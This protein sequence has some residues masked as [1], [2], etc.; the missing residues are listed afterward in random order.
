MN[1]ILLQLGLTKNEAKIYVTLLRLGPAPAGKITEESGIH[2]RNVYDSLERLMAKGLAGHSTRG[3]IRYFEAANP[4]KLLELI[5]AEKDSLRS[6]EKKVHSVLTELLALRKPIQKEN[7]IIYKGVEG[8]KTILDDVLSTGKENLVLG[9]H[10]PP[11]QIRPYLER[12]HKKRVR[13]GLADKLLFNKNDV[14]RARRLSKMPCTE[15]KFL[16]KKSE[17]QS[18]I[19]IYGNKVAIIM[20][21]DPVGILIENRNVAQAFREYFRLLWGIS[22]SK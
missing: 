9:A 20:W 18:S 19:N 8:V 10:R 2:R 21:S 16:P 6:K 11:A 15:I 17:S 12:F 4:Y 5:S 14:Q 13:I 1:D 3:K 22:K 7:V